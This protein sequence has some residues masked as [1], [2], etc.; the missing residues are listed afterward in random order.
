[1][2]TLGISHK[3]LSIL[4]DFPSIGH[5]REMFYNSHQGDEVE[6]PLKVPCF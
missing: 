5:G 2:L 1:M 3:L 6:G 4:R